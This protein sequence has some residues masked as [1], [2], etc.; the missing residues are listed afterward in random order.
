MNGERDDYLFRLGASRPRA[1]ASTLLIGAWLDQTFSIGHN[2]TTYLILA[3]WALLCFLLGSWL[4]SGSRDRLLFD[5]ATNQEVHIGDRH[6]LYYIQVQYWAFIIVA[7]GGLLFYQQ[8]QSGEIDLNASSSPTASSQAATKSSSSEQHADFDKGLEAYTQHKYADALA[9]FQPAAERGDAKAEI[10]MGLMYANG[11]GVAEDDAKAFGLFQKAADQGEVPAQANLGLF[12][13]NGWG[14]PKDYGKALA[15]YRKAADAGN[16]MAQYSLGSMYLDG[17]GAERNLT[18][19]TKWLTKAADQGSEP[20]K[21]ALA[22][23]RQASSSPTYRA[24][25]INIVFVGVTPSNYENGHAGLCTLFANIHNNTKYHLTKVG[26]KI[27]DWSF[28]IDDELNANWNLD[29]YKIGDV[30]LSAGTTCSGQAV[31]LKSTAASAGVSDC[32]MPGVA[33]GDCQQM[34]T[35]S[36]AIDDA[37]INKIV[38]LENSLGTRQIAPLRDAIARAGLA[39]HN[40]GPVSPERAAGFAGL[41]DTFVQIDSQGWGFNKYVAGSM[42]NV[43]VVGQTANGASIRLKGVYTYRQVENVLRG[44]VIATIEDGGLKCLEYHDRGGE[45]RAINLPDVSA[46][47]VTSD[48]SWPK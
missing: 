19:A 40:P 39:S 11:L 3:V 17:R 5:P 28:A 12:Y 22:D 37:T 42:S 47:S 2:V 44:W 1:G 16:A 8:V 23:V 7:G 27:D 15:A 35:I 30:T 10:Y 14:I 26:F 48:A 43:S 31:F 32:V 25:K 46:E 18:E 33:E 36:S 34:V 45:C 38:D 24:G 6:A 13:E 20:A 4:N 21:K 9:I 41:L 29:N